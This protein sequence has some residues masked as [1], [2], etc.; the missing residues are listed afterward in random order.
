[1]QINGK[2]TGEGTDQL[3]SIENVVASQHNDV[4][5]G[6]G[7]AN[8]IEGRGGNDDLQ[9]GAGN[10]QIFGGDG[11]DTLHGGG[12][13]DVFQYIF[14]DNPPVK[15]ATLVKGEDGSDTVVDFSFS[16]HDQVSLAVFNDFFDE[17]TLSVLD[18][19]GEITVAKAGIDQADVKI[20]FAGGGSILL[21][22]ILTQLEEDVDSLTEINDAAG[23]QAIK[24]DNLTSSA[25]F[26]LP[27]DWPPEP[28]WPDPPLL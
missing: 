1:L 21:K 23:Y 11:D 25:V 13:S 20:G 27:P 15:D 5:I 2:V 9:G 26:I 18:A 3:I 7:G 17:A 10:D 12:G 14:N 4:V 6:A 8:R 16:S 24:I 28:P 19:S 22:N